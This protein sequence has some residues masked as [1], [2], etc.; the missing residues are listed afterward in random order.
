[1]SAYGDIKRLVNDAPLSSTIWITAALNGNESSYVTVHHLTLPIA[2]QLPG[3][4]TY[5]GA[6]FAKEVEDGL[7]YPQEGEMGQDTFEA[8]F[9]AADVFVGIVG[10]S[11]R[12]DRADAAIELSIEEAQVGRTWEE[13]VAGYYYVGAI[14]YCTDTL[15]FALM[16]VQV[17]PNYP[18][19]S[20]HVSCTP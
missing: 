5:L 12:T 7:T 11:P 16:R 18:G 13:C 8:Y 15:L 9:F 3:L 10:G 17:K 2:R 20:S 19:R 4:L 14:S 1:M 6:V